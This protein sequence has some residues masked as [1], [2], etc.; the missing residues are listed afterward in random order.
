MIPERKLFEDREPDSDAAAVQRVRDWCDQQD[1]LSKGESP[2][3]AA[4]RALLDAPQPEGVGTG[5]GEGAPRQDPGSAWV[6]RSADCPEAPAQAHPLAE[7]SRLASAA[8]PGPWRAN[9]ASEWLTTG[10]TW[11]VVFTGPADDPLVAG[12]DV[13]LANYVEQADA[14]FIA[15]AREAV[16]AL[17]AEVERLRGDLEISHTIAAVRTE[18]RDRIRER[19]SAVRVLVD[20]W[21]ITGCGYNHAGQIRA[22]LDAPQAEAAGQAFRDGECA[23]LPV[24]GAC[25]T[26]PAAWPSSTSRRAAS[27]RRAEDRG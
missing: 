14:E 13:A 1:Q 20:G 27:P 8:T 26:S 2:T 10:P 17:V 19:L 23:P 11:E 7:W 22:V 4:V 16:P 18:H 21:G 15:A 6:T 9:D 24:A 5:A 3:T 12:E 25:A